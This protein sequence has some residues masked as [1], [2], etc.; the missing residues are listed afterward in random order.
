MVMMEE[1]QR[2]VRANGRLIDSRNLHVGVS[3]T[4]PSRPMP[5]RGH[6]RCC[7][8]APTMIRMGPDRRE[9]QPIRAA[10]AAGYRHQL[11]MISDTL[12]GNGGKDPGLR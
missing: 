1:P 3:R 11:G 2:G 8:P 9:P 6:H 7:Q 5:E 10:V 4:L 12:T